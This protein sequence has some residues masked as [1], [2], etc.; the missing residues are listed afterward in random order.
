MLQVLIVLLRSTLE[1]SSFIFHSMTLTQGL[2]I[3]RFT[4]D[5]HSRILMICLTGTNGLPHGYCENASWVA[6]IL[7]GAANMPHGYLR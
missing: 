2:N 1:E 5:I 7:I 4:D 3:L 6:D